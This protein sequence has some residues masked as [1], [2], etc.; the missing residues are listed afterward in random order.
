MRLTYTALSDTLM[1]SDLP[2]LKNRMQSKA[3]YREATHTDCLK[4]IE[5]SDDGEHWSPAY[6]IGRSLFG[7]FITQARFSKDIK[8]SKMSRVL[9]ED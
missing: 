3:T 5:V 6:Y 4:A 9:I 2:Q 1:A 8:S 7:Q